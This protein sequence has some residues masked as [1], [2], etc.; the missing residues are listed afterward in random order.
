ME[1]IKKAAAELVEEMDRQGRFTAVF[2]ALNTGSGFHP[3]IVASQTLGVLR[4]IEG[5]VD[6][7]IEK[8]NLHQLQ[9]L[10]SM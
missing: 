8:I 9:I 5:D 1:L 7:A 4:N 2:Y 6:M 3:V 10:A